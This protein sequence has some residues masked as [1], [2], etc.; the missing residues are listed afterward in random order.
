M[1]FLSLF[2][3]VFL[4]LLA[5]YAFWAVYVH[6][7][8]HFTHLFVGADLALL[9]HRLAQLAAEFALSVRMAVKG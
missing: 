7:S 8:N 5:V 6:S 2:N 4:L 9:W 3:F 1:F